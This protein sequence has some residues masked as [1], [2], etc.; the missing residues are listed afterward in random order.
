M[1]ELIH[2]TFVLER[3]KQ[4]HIERIKH[5]VDSFANRIE[6]KCRDRSVLNI[7]LAAMFDDY[8]QII[9]HWL[10]QE[11]DISNLETDKIKDE[12][13]SAVATRLLTTRRLD[14]E[15]FM[16]EWLKARRVNTDSG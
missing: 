14:Y 12:T 6:R 7:D 4:I 10:H 16:A 9:V 15:R 2:A 11:M 5:N 8:G 3:M 1:E 13:L